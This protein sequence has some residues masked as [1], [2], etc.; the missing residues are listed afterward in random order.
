[1]N[2][3]TIGHGMGP[4]NFHRAILYCMSSAGAK[5]VAVRELLSSDK[6]SPS[7]CGKTLGGYRVGRPCPTVT[8]AY[9]TNR[10][11]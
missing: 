4:V 3:A 9:V 5:T 8:V 10:V 2:F 1:M 7:R 11:T 6:I